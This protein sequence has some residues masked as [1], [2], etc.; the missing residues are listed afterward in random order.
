MNPTTLR[1]SHPEHVHTYLQLT[2]LLDGIQHDHPEVSAPLRLRLLR[3]RRDGQ[4]GSLDASAFRAVVA[5]VRLSS[6]ESA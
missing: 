6:S 1:E 3:A 4:L 2:R 5:D